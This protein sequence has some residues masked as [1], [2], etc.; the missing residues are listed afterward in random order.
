M[1]S[2]M[3]VLCII[4]NKITGTLYGW[5]LAANSLDKFGGCERQTDAKLFARNAYK[6]FQ[7]KNATIHW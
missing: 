4:E 6:W 2:T 5:D 1:Y 3:N 7:H